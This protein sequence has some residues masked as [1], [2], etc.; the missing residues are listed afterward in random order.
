MKYLLRLIIIPMVYLLFFAFTTIGIASIEAFSQL[1]KSIISSLLLVFYIIVIAPIMI[2]EGQDAY[3]ILLSNDAQRRR[4]VET[5]IV[6]DFDTS[7]EYRP[8]KGFAVGLIC[9]IPLVLMVFFHLIS[10][11]GDVSALSKICEMIY[12]VFYSIA[13]TYKN[14]NELGFYIGAGI[15]LIVLPLMTGVPYVIGAHNRRLQQEKI[16]KI[17][18]ELHGAKR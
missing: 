6:V 16:K 12:G 18:D 1:V 5:G 7:K 3:G 15:I 9:C 14:T 13:R 2:K 17:N 10:S 11:S 8:W 4:I